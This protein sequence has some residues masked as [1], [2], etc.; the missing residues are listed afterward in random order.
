MS[1]VALWIVTACYA[2]STA[3]MIMRGKGWMAGVFA[4]YAV[5]AVCLIY[6][7]RD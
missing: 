3:E 2:I 4:A 1:H 6:A 7:T 5:S